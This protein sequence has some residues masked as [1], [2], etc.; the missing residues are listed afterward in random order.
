MWH[1]EAELKKHTINFL[2]KNNGFTENTDINTMRWN[3]KFQE[4]K[5]RFDGILYRS[6]KIYPIFCKIVGKKSVPLNK[7][8]TQLFI[9]NFV[10]VKKK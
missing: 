6:N 9:K 7:E 1:N 10:S 4:K 2:E 5:V 8:M 3:L